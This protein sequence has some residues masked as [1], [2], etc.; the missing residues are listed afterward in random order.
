M[1]RL[2]WLRNFIVPPN[3]DQ[4][5][6]HERSEITFEGGH[7]VEVIPTVGL[8]NSLKRTISNRRAANRVRSAIGTA[9]A[10]PIRG[11]CS[12]TCRR[13]SFCKGIVETW[14]PGPKL[15]NPRSQLLRS[16]DCL[17]KWPRHLFEKSVSA[18]LNTDCDA[19]GPNTI[20]AQVA[21][22][23]QGTLI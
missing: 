13:P 14:P 15:D 2:D 18:M 7:D 23:C 17:S 16:P 1:M 6:C 5:N 22:R 9:V 10:V 3:D 21:V 20:R 11:P 12:K 8:C 19:E 4:P